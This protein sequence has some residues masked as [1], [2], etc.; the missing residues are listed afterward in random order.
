MQRSYNPQLTNDNTQALAYSASQTASKTAHLHSIYTCTFGILFFGT[1]HTGTSK[2]HLL[3]SLQKVVSLTVP[4]KIFETDSNL[5]DALEE[6]S[7]VL[8]NINDQ[9]A[10]LLPR[11]RVFF[12]WEQERTSLPHSRAYVVDEQSAAP[13]HDGTERCG[14]AADH[15]GMCKFESRNSPGFRTVVAALRRYCQ[16][17]PE[18]IKARCTNA[19]IMLNEQRRH[20]AGELLKGLPSDSGRAIPVSSLSDEHSRDRHLLLWE[21]VPDDQP[22]AETLRQL[23]LCGRTSLMT[24]PSRRP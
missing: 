11:F 24:N 3:G 5:L 6:G 20:E 14:I 19:R 4:R 9:F 16:E 7:E 1:P 22:Y 18:T 10:S 17:G 8:Q 21:N 23:E 12:L 13:I 15:R 2:A